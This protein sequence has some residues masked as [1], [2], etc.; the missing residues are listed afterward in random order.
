MS[1]LS[2]LLVPGRGRA[3]SVKGCALNP[4]LLRL[5]VVVE[6]DR[7]RWQLAENCVYSELARVIGVVDV[8]VQAED[9]IAGPG[10]GENAQRVGHVPHGNGGEGR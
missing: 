2:S 1:L 10:L 4:L 8:V 9:R 5:P 3:F 6:G 7:A